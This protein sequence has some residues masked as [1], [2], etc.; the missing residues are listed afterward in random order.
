M[1]DFFNGVAILV[2]SGLY[3]T[4]LK[5]MIVISVLWYGFKASNG[6]LMEALKWVLTVVIILY[7]ML[8]TKSSVVIEDR[9]NPG[10][11]GNKIDN[12]PFGLAVIAGVSSS[13]GEHLTK[14]FEQMFSL[15]NDMKYS[16]NGLI[17]GARVM[18][19]TAFAEFAMNGGIEEQQRFKTNFQEFIEACVLLNAQQ[20]VPYTVSQLKTSTNLW[21]LISSKDGLSPIF[22][23]KYLKSNNIQEFLTCKD[24]IDSIQ[25]DLNKQIAL[26]EGFLASKL[27]PNYDDALSKYQT[28]H[29]I[30]LDY[31][32]TASK[33]ASDNLTQAIMVNEIQQSVG[34][35]ASSIG[36]N[37]ITPYEQARMDIQQQ[38]T[39]RVIGANAGSW[40]ILTKTLL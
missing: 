18:K 17:L 39:Y 16:E 12:I 8:F 26:T 30:T 9:A 5:I 6:A 7:T 33:T 22:T 21:E 37:T 20:G 23:F 34:N 28:T 38:N 10:L 40:I 2:N 15:P 4:S 24:G 32:T 35:Y 1:R 29:K 3:I 31:L 25:N 11:S 19:E 13:L 36:S 27:F 14:G